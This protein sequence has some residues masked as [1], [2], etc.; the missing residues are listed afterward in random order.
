MGRRMWKCCGAWLT[1]LLTVVMMLATGGVSRAQLAGDANCDGTVNG[2]DLTALIAAIF[3]ATHNGCSTADANGDGVVDSADVVALTQFVNAPPAIGPVVTFLGLAGP[4]GSAASSLGQINGAPVYF[5]TSGFGFKIIVEGGIGLSGLPP[6]TVSFNTSPSDPSQRPDLQ[7]ESSNPLGDASVVVCDGGVPAVHPPNFGLDQAIANALNDF[8][9]NFI[10]STSPN[11]ACT[12]NAFGGT[13]FLGQGTQV[14]FCAQ[15]TRALSLPMDQTVLSVRLRDTAGNLGPVQQLIL[16]VGSGAMPPT[17]TPVLTPTRATPRP[18]ATATA[19]PTPTRTPTATRAPSATATRTRTRTPTPTA[20]L[21]LKPQTQTLTPTVT[22][23]PRPSATKSGTGA[24]VATPTRT[25]SPTRS[26]TRSPTPSVTPSVG[27]GP[28]ITFFGLTRSDDTLMPPTD[29][30]SNGL[31]IYAR[32]TGASFSLVVEGKPGPSGAAVGLSAYSAAQCPTPNPALAAVVRREQFAPQVIV[33]SFPDLQIEVS[34]PLGNGSATVCDNSAP[35]VG[36]V[37]AINP[38]SFQPTQGNIN[39]TNDLGC[40]FLDGDNRPC[41]RAKSDGCVLFLSGEFGFVDA[42]STAQFCGLIS[43]FLEF[44]PGDTVVT[45]RLQDVGGNAGAAAQLVLRVVTPTLTPAPASPQTSTPGTSTPQV[46]PPVSPTKTA[47]RSPTATLAT[48]RTPTRTRTPTMT[49]TSM[50]TGPIIT[51][52]GLTRADDTPLAASGT[53][54][55]GQ[56][57]FTRSLGSSFSIVIEGKPGSSGIEVGT[58]A[59]Q[60]NLTS[61]P[62]LQVEVSRLLGNG[63]SAVCDKSGA[64]PG[65][66]PAVNPPSFIATSAN[67]NAVND[68]G[69]RFEN[70]SGDPVGRAPSEACIMFPSG[71][72]GYMNSKST[73][74][75]CG[76]IG[77]VLEFPSDDTV[78]TARLLDK[79]GNPGP[80]AQIVV[81]IGP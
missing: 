44:P 71:D 54:A 16:R 52:F 81:R 34:R 8:A 67:I 38:P 58:S 62:D 73:I 27:T 48:T 53:T 75:F 60:A 29:M 45:V 18:T 76:F 30:T 42:N 66:V 19:P 28:V 20:T 22:P 74:Q 32:Q 9:C 57:I 7:I 10:A 4:D 26:A 46:T 49:P 40:R 51:F 35:T 13:S 56:P 6:G 72:F 36:G 68:L 39:A 33:S 70:G 14:Q 50:L 3:D 65:G 25:P 24:A 2:D 17:F 31:P 59:Y 12:Q 79:A 77:R 15:V 5:R 11:F 23:S 41:G 37:P 80:S 64:S 61:F 21:I 47:T 43:S 69:C 78:V 63:S 55:Q 1:G